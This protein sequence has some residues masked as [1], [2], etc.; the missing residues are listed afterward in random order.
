MIICNHQFHLNLLLNQGIFHGLYH[1]VFISRIALYSI[2][3]SNIHK[4]WNILTGKQMIL[5]WGEGR[6]VLQ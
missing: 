3:D 4:K 1:S 6:M 5:I 2:K